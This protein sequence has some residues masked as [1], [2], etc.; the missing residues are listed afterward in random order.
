MTDE[1]LREAIEGALGEIANGVRRLRR[2]DL[3][4]QVRLS[5]LLAIRELVRN[6][7]D[8]PLGSLST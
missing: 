3:P 5:E 7:V 4:S 8:R 2:Q 6:E 1:Q